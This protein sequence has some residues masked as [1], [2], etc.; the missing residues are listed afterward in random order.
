VL[1]LLLVHL[2]LFLEELAAVHRCVEAVPLEEL[3]VRAALGDQSVVE[4]EWGLTGPPTKTIVPPTTTAAKST[5][6]A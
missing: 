4:I 5:S 1:G 2:E 3:A 6:T